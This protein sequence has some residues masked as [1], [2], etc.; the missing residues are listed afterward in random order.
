MRKSA[1]VC[2]ELRNFCIFYLESCW[3]RR[4]G[5][6]P[7]RPANRGRVLWLEWR[8][9]PGAR[10]PVRWSESLLQNFKFSFFIFKKIRF[11][12]IFSSETDSFWKRTF[13]IYFSLNNRYFLKFFC[14]N[15]NRQERPSDTSP[16][17]IEP[18]RMARNPRTDSCWVFS[19]SSSS[20]TSSR[21]R[22]WPALREAGFWAEKLKF[23]IFAQLFWFINKKRLP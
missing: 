19:C 15:S 3:R 11:F 2:S 8:P 10:N 18:Y 17:W 22:L 16:L 9:D 5:P 13:F 21:G 14:S 4:R 12:V 6:R 7:W 20:R 1:W 23:N